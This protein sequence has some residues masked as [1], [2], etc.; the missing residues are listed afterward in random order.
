MRWLTPVIHCE[1]SKQ[2]LRNV[3]LLDSLG[4]NRCFLIGHSMSYRKLISIIE[5]VKKEYPNNWIGVNF[6]DLDPE[7]AL[8]AVSEEVEVNALWLDDLCIDEYAEVQERAARIKEKKP[9]DVVLFGGIAFKYQREVK[10]LRKV[11]QEAIK[12]CDVPTTSGDGTGLAANLAKIKAIKAA[13]GKNHLAI[14]SGITP[15]NVFDY[16]DDVNYFLVATG[17][18]QSFTELDS[19]KV[20]QL[21]EN[22]EKEKYLVRAQF[23]GTLSLGLMNGVP[24]MNLEMS[25]NNVVVLNNLEKQLEQFGKPVPNNT[26]DG[27][28]IWLNNS[29]VERI[30]GFDDVETV[31]LKEKECN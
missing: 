14:A 27:F 7:M 8:G 12:F 30:S 23:T 6:L 26:K 13:L 29:E 18:S 19:A 16:M 9:D 22:L 31:T 17:I 20:K 21:K 5:D 2:A 11:A 25:E 3:G 10:D 1:S 24:S 4:I 15:E 28:Y